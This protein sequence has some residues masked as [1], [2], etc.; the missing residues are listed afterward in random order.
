MNKAQNLLI[1]LC[2]ISFTFELDCSSLNQDQC[3]TYNTLNKLQCHKF[4]TEDKCAEVIVDDGCQINSSHQ[5]TKTDQDSNKYECYFS[6]PNTNKICRRINLDTGCMA[7]ISTTVPILECEK[8]S[9]SEDIEENQDC[10][11]SEDKKTCQKKTKSCELY[12]DS[13]CGGLEGKK[14]NKKCLI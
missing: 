11:L 7:K 14:N 13:D 2:L 8:N 3:S 12:S 10:F 5:C 1:A 6:A 9:T 4:A